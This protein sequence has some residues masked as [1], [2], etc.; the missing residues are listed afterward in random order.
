MKTKHALHTYHGITFRDADYGWV[1]QIR[2]AGRYRVLPAFAPDAETA[3]RRHDIALSKLRAFSDVNALPNFPEA[4][5]G[6]DIS[7]DPNGDDN[8]KKFFDG[9]SSMFTTLC[10]E[11]EDAGIDVLDLEKQKNTLAKT[12]RDRKLA[13]SLVQRNKVIGS[14]VSA[15]TKLDCFSLTRENRARVGVLLSAAVE[16]LTK[17]PDG[18]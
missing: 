5:E 17:N 10:K 11:C 13:A 3:A 9:L 1:I 6:L 7:R 4:F 15:Q 8:Y 16:L 14:L 2:L 12:I 18:Q